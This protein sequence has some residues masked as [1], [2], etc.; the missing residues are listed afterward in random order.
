MNLNKF[1]NSP[2]VAPLLVKL[3]DSHKLY[4]LAKQDMPAART[5]LSHAVVSLFEADINGK[6]QELLA[7]ILIALMR[8]AETELR[9]VLSEKLATLD[10][11]PLRLVLH[12]A[13]DEITVASPMLEKST[14]LSDLDIIYIIKSRGAAYWQAIAK[15][16]R[17][18]NEAIDMLVDSGDFGTAVILSQNERIRLTKYAL[19]ILGGHSKRA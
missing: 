14:V 3:Y 13:N 15:R 9:G 16:S 11:I 1:D 2:H 17:L 18:S 4:A 5:E 12:L 8:R 19:G 6:E 7:D 10:N